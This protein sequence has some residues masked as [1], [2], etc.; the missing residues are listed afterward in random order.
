MTE[1]LRYATNR[2][3]GYDGMHDSEREIMRLFDAGIGLKR[4]VEITG[5]TFGQVQNV[6]SMFSA[7]ALVEWKPDA[8]RG[9]AALLT[10]LRQHHPD[11]CG[12][13]S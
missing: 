6:T 10:A 12:A 11:R 4:I 9:S 5:L 13:I 7:T 1:R 8:K 3:I 2:P